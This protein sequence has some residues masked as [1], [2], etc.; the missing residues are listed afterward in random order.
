MLLLHGAHR[1]AVDAPL[2][3]AST[4][5]PAADLDGVE[6]PAVLLLDHLNNSLLQACA[7]QACG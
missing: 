3:E 2:R 4:E 7:R 1:A 5:H 6:P